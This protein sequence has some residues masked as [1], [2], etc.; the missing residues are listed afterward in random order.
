M[1]TTRFHV[2]QPDGSSL[3]GQACVATILGIDL[4]QAITLV[5]HSHGTKPRELSETLRKH[6]LP[7]FVRRV[8]YTGGTLPTK[9]FLA[10]STPGTRSRY[11][12]ALLDDGIVYDPSLVTPW[13][14]AEYLKLYNG[15]FGFPRLTSYLPIE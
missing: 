2:R 11:H 13:Y 12:W 1:I 5:G 10:L 6:G 14:L 3:C 9:A 7:C 15:S 4:E 8:R